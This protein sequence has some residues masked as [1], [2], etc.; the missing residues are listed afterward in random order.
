M[1]VLPFALLLV[2]CAVADKAPP[3]ASSNAR[4]DAAP[5]KTMIGQP[6]TAELA[7]KALRLSGSRT[8]RW[9]PPGAVMT[10]DYRIDRLNVSLDAQNQIT[11]F[12][13]G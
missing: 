6:A 2:G 8:L 3:T 11:G 4:C 9:K 13:C 7:A 12:D 10:M 5:L 1:R